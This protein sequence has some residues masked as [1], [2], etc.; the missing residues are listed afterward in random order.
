MPCPLPIPMGQE[1][2]PP[3]A[4]APQSLW[5]AT[6]GWFHDA[7]ELLRVRLALLGV[8]ARG[9]A[10]DV[11]EGLAA[12]VVAALLLVLGVGFLAVLLTVL[13]WESH[14]LL[15]LALFS[16]VFLTLGVVALLWARRRLLGIRW[17]AAS[18]SELDR[19]LERLRGRN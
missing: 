7:G 17:F 15:A 11:A 2:R 9:H 1:D 13:L 10:L 12:T 6:R 19:D 5:S 16:A 4:E 14:R 3:S 8:E 18:M